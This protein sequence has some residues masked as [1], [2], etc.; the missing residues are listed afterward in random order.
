MSVQPNHSYS[1]LKWMFLFHI[2][3]A[4]ITKIWF[5]ICNRVRLLS[6]FTI[7]VVQ[8]NITFKIYWHTQTF[9]FMYLTT[10]LIVFSASPHES[11]HVNHLQLCFYRHKVVS[12]INWTMVKHWQH[13]DTENIW[14]SYIC[15]KWK[16]NRSV[17]YY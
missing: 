13:Y 7:Q 5:L 10:P 17:Q 14:Y 4:I 6:W 16:K 8:E 1:F 12:S 11:S 2:K 3:Y 15:I 9:L